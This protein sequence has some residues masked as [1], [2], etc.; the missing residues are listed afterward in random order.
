MPGMLSEIASKLDRGERLTLEDG[1]ALFEHPD[2]LDSGGACQQ[3][4]RAASRR[5]HVLQLQHPHRGHERLRGELSV[6]LVRAAAARRS[7]LL[8]DGAGGRVGEAA[9]ARRSAAHRSPRR[10]RAASG[11]TVRLLPRAAARLQAHPSRDSSEVLHRSRD[12]VLRGSLRH[13]RR[14]GACAS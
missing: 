5:P 1:V 4:A 2:L 10:Q 11:F 8:H 3:R 6:L 14:A 9:G 7:R 12:C 13:D